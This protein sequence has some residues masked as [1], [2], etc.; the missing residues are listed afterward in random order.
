MEIVRMMAFMVLKDFVQKDSMDS[1]DSTEVIRE[2]IIHL[3]VMD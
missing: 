1:E 2:F 3:E